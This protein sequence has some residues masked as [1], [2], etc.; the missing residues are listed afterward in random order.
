MYDDLYVYFAALVVPSP[1]VI[2]NT[3]LDSRRLDLQWTQQDTDFIEEYTVTV[4][5]TPLGCEALIEDRVSTLG[6]LNRSLLVEE[7]EEFSNITVVL[8]ARNKL[9]NATTA[10]VVTTMSAGELRSG[11]M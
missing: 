8:V 6:G 5:A 2:S 1:P 11:M 7:L 3:S 4:T 9:G 10:V